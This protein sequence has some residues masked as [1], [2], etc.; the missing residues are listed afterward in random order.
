MGVI[1]VPQNEE[2]RLSSDEV[3]DNPEN[4][5][6]PSAKSGSA[7]AKRLNWLM[8]VASILV[9]TAVVFL[10]TTSA[11]GASDV[12][13]RADV[14][15]SKSLKNPALTTGSTIDFKYRLIQG[16][17]EAPLIIE[18]PGG[19]GVSSIS[20]ADPRPDQRL[21]WIQIDPRNTGC[22]AG[23]EPMISSDT[24]VEIYDIAKIIVDLHPQ[25]FFVFG[26]SYGS[27]VATRLV[28]YLE[29]N[30]LPKPAGLILQGIIGHSFKKLEQENAFA[31]QWQ[32]YHSYFSA[33]LA[34]EFRKKMPFGVGKVHWV[35]YIS[36]LL[37]FGETPDKG[38]LLMGMLKDLKNPASRRGLLDSIRTTENGGV[39]VDVFHFVGC[40]EVFPTGAQVMFSE[41]L[42]V[43]TFNKFCAD[44]PL[45]NPYD[46][47]TQQVHAPIFYFSGQQDPATPFNQAV[48]HYKQQQFAPKRFI[49]VPS[50]SHNALTINL[51]DCYP[52]LLNSI[53]FGEKR[54]EEVLPTC[55][56]K[57]AELSA[58]QL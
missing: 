30:A 50:G 27:I 39:Q 14:H 22:N 18:I 17:P 23:L 13:A 5:G 38:D 12:C 28:Y 10:G 24:A 32:K 54:L 21:N 25:K 43:P 34:T 41:G 9:S 16:D 42:F 55:K 46:S 15:I 33:E 4:N 40:R 29:Q 35:S 45:V 6:P 48:Y 20:E 1:H 49:T 19:P 2:L 53:V 3:L 56:V 11:W 26:T 8:G 47:A 31:Q 57:A 7:G 51:K 36:N 37:Y 58:S 52:A 44:Q